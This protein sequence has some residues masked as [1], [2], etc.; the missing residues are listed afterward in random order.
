[1]NLVWRMQDVDLAQE[2]RE[3]AETHGKDNVLRPDPQTIMISP[4]TACGHI[5]FCFVTRLC[6]TLRNRVSLS[7]LNSFLLLGIDAFGLS[8]SLC[9]PRSL[10]LGRVVREKCLN[11]T[12]S[13]LVAQGL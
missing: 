4:A 13:H 3:E 5:D 8:A 6:W 10:S 11:R 2:S 7:V 9:T 1:M 12:A